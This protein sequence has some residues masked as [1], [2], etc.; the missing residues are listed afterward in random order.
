MK[1]LANQR[2]HA[3]LVVSEENRSSSQP[4]RQI[5]PGARHSSLGAFTLIELLVVIA[6]IAILAA[7]LLPALAKAKE[8]AHR[9]SCFNNLR[10]TMIAANLYADEWPNYYYYTTD[11]GDDAAPLSFYP[12]LIREVKVFNCPSTRNVIRADV[13]D[14]QGIMTDLKVTCH[15]DRASTVYKNGISYEYFGFFQTDPWSG[16][17][18]PDY[19]NPG[20]IRKSPKTVIKNPTAVVIVLDADDVLPAPYPSG[21]LNRNNRPDPINNHGSGGWNWGFADGH[22]EWVRAAQTYQKLLDSWMTSGTEYGPGP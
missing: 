2:L 8:K 5:T 16:A 10:Q 21:S 11:I 17:A 14:R 7:M 9:T 6:I 3:L 15:G 1:K 22:A 19:P 13:L 4:T 12:N 18:L 20:Y